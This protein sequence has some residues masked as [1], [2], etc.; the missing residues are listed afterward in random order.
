MSDALLATISAIMIAS[1]PGIYKLW[2]DRNAAREKAITQA[3]ERG[4]EKAEAAHRV[5]EAEAAIAQKNR[6][7]ETK[8]AL[9]AEK[10]E[11][12]SECMERTRDLREII[13]N[14]SKEGRS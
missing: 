4:F 8:D 1:V 2:K 11:A 5:R 14:L 12:L 7:L 13:T 9:I 10:D 6:E 3:T